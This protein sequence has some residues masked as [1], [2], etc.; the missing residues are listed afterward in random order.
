MMRTW[1]VLLSLLGSATAV[2]DVPVTNRTQ[3]M[4]FPR[5]AVQAVAAKA[6]HQE[7]ARLSGQGELDREQR[8]L[9][10]V[11]R[12][13]SRLIAQAILLKP[14]AKDWPWEVHVTSDPRI[15][16]YSMG[17]GKLLV[18]THFIEHYQLSDDEL[19]VAL[20]HE[21]SHVIAEHVREQV[22][23][24]ALFNGSAPGHVSKV[25]DVINDM[26]SDIG[27]FLSLQPLSRLQELEADDIGIELAARAGVP[28]TAITSFYAK[29]AQ[30]GRGQ[31]LFDTHGP[32]VQRVK[33]VDS[34]AKYARP[35][36][37]ASRHARALPHYTFTDAHQHSSRSL[38]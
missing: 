20:A 34:M 24:V 36:Y 6:Y 2:A 28:P 10:K 7:L 30:T 12:L 27:V 13:S 18:G 32:V 19:A 1:F 9:E 11:R 23:M 35:V 29:L 38:K 25:S 3:N 37:E 17:G 21:I 5:N 4:V 14:A 16:A 33:F 22:S 26:Q 15:S 8:Y 31:S